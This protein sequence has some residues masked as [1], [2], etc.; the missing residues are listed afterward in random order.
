MGLGDFAAQHGTAGESVLG[1]A[2]VS[3]PVCSV[4]A[5]RLLSAPEMREWGV[6]GVPAPWA[7]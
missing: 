2:R 4:G 6:R 7:E 5:P 3:F 1:A